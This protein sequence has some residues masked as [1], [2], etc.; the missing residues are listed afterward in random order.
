MALSDTLVQFTAKAP[1]AKNRVDILLDKLVGTD[2]FPVLSAALR[3]RLV[4]GADLTKA[5]RKE[6]GND[7]VTDNSVGEWRRKNLAEVDGL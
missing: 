7:A 1:A 5:L 6:Y 3:N 2:D 4:R